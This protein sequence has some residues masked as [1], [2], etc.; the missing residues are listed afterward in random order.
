MVG[1]LVVVTCTYLVVGVLFATAAARNGGGGGI[2]GNA[3]EWG[4]GNA[5]SSS[6]GNGSSGGSSGGGGGGGTMSLSPVQSVVCVAAFVVLIVAFQ[7]GPG[8]L[9]LTI[10]PELFDSAEER[11]WG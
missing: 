8:T 10:L 7:L 5:S 11:A 6:N 2:G 1:G 4:H 3:S 9:F